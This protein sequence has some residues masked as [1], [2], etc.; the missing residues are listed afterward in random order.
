LSDFSK[1]LITAFSDPARRDRLWMQMVLAI[2]ATS[3]PGFIEQRIMVAFSGI[4]HVM[5]Q[6]LVLAGQRTERDYMREEAAS[7]LREVLKAA[8]VPAEIDG[9]LQSVMARLA[10]AKASDGLTLDGVGTPWTTG[11]P[12]VTS[13]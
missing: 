2:S 12:V 5:W 11:V 3:T 1:L 6:N 9:N 7:L 13:G 4:E 8:S 10:A